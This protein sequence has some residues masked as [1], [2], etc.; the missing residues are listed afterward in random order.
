MV[1]LILMILIG[2]VGALV[3]MNMN[4]PAEP[5]TSGTLPAKDLRAYMQRQVTLDDHPCKNRTRCLVVYLSPW[6]PSC[7]NS[8]HFV[9]YVREAIAHHSDTGFVVVVGKAWGDFNGGYEMA[10]DIGGQVYIDAESRYWNELRPEVNAIPAWLVI[11]GDGHVDEQH[12]GS[13]GRHDVQTA[14]TF[15]AELSIK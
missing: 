5:F 12:T 11:D 14:N 8:K 7:R 4:Q 3:W 1:K 2:V 9:P 6:C 15:L 13:P 10:R